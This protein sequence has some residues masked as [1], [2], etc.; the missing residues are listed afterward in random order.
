LADIDRLRAFIAKTSPNS[1][2][3]AI[4][5]IMKGV[6]Q[7]SAFPLLGIVVDRL[8]REL[9]LR[10]GKGA[11]IVRYRLHEGV[12]VITRIWHSHEDRSA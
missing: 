12:V 8:Y 5:R 9:A 11:Y 1:A 4:D 6:G 7:L 2:D 3:A 10:Y